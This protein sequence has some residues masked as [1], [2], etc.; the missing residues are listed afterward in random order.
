M[1]TATT[2]RKAATKRSTTAKTTAASRSAAAKKAAETRAE[3]AKTPVDRAVEYAEKAVLVPVGAVL[4]ARDNVIS[5]VGELRTSYSTPEKAQREL[6]RF[7]RRGTTARNRLERE[8]RKTRTRVER[9]L[10]QRRARTQ[11]LLKQNRTRVERELK[12]RTKT[13]D[14]AQ[15]R[16]E[17]ALQSGIDTATQLSTEIQKR[18]T[19]VA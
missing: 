6:R 8:V 12:A 18:F 11:R 4:I 19:S 7:E 5:T 10:R 1:A 16:F 9:E 3:N 2:T 13:V 15:A 17:T 14:Q